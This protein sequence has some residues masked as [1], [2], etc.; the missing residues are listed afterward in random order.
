MTSA[1]KIDSLTSPPPE[2][3]LDDLVTSLV[4]NRDDA[5]SSVSTNDDESSLALLD[6]KH[7]ARFV[8]INR[9][10]KKTE[11]TFIRGRIHNS[12]VK[13]SVWLIL[14]I[15]YFSFIVITTLFHSCGEHCNI[16]AL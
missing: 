12:I 4:G 1:A 9:P 10:I 2:T 13:K 5:M 14:R 8:M 16:N 15:L 6:P 3:V 7:L 11:G